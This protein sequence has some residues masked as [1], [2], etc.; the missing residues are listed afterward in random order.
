MR[1][2]ILNAS[3]ITVYGNFTYKAISLDQARM[4]AYN[5]LDPMISPNDGIL[6]AIGHQSTAEILT[7]LLQIPIDMNRITF[8]HKVGQSAI[9][10]KL[11]S[12]I[13]E[14]AILSREEVEKIGYKFGLL[15]RIA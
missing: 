11:K 12:R 15:I 6:S 5:A 10:F 9:M 14:G 2:A 3:T 8:E 7:E 4:L 1:L 13:P